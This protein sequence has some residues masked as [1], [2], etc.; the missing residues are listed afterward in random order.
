MES[1]LPNTSLIDFYNLGLAGA[2]G[3]N[4]DLAVNEG[5]VTDFLLSAAAAMADRCDQERAED[6][7]NTHVDGA[8]GDKLTELADDRYDVDRQPATAATCTVQY[9]RPFDAGAEPSGTISAGFEVATQVDAVGND[10]RFVTDA[11]LN[12]ALGQL[13]GS[14]G[15][16]AIET[17]PE[18]NVDQAGLVTRMIDT[19]FD[20]TF[21][22]TNTTPAAGGNLEESDAE[23]RTRIRNR[24]A[25]YS[26]A[27][28][29]AI[30][31]GALE[32]DIVRVASATE[33]TSTGLV[34]LSISDADGNSNAQ[35]INDV[36]LEIE[37]WRAFGIPITVVGGVRVVVDL[38]VQLTLTDGA[39]LSG[40][41]T[42]VSDAISGEIDKLS[43]GATLYDTLSIAA[44]KNVAPELIHD[45]TITALSIGGTPVT[46]GDYTPAVN[47]LL[48]AGTITVTSA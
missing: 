6:H 12:F 33:D 20:A 4:P 25:S 45:V 18:G 16:T 37:N 48:R 38:T 17:G 39:A 11:D 36:L 47:E 28:K 2:V 15:C 35:M 43:Q 9:T 46:I 21:A 1:P 31:A 40:L 44:A 3:A 19:P 34:T 41:Q 42:P 24:P 30:E 5:D 22:V 26:R 7:R 32:V 14:I 13:T 10:I 23:V 8:E 29:T 27:T